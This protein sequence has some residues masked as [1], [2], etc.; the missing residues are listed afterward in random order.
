MKTAAFGLALIILSL[1]KLIDLI[2]L[3]ATHLT[4][5]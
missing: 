1:W 5:K 2:L 3:V 4:W